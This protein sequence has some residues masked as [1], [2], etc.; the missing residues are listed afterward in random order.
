MLV[1]RGANTYLTDIM[2]KTASDYARLQRHYTIATLRWNEW[3]RVAELMIG[4]LKTA[5]TAQF[6]S[7][8]QPIR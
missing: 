2:G 6:P 7:Q 3:Q 8:V 4:R 5:S 1:Q